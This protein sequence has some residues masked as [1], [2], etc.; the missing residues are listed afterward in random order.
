MLYFRQ[1]QAQ[2][3]VLLVIRGTNTFTQS[4]ATAPDYTWQGNTNTGIFHPATNVIGF[5]NAGAESMRII[6]D[7]AAG[8]PKVIIGTGITLPTSTTYSYSLYVSRGILAERVKVAI[9]TTTDW[10]DKVFTKDHKL[11]SLSELKSFINENGH[12]PN[13]PS[14]EEV[15]KSGID[16]GE[17]DAK[18]L[19]KIE[20]LTLHVIRLEEEINKLKANQNEK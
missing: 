2:L 15:V 9:H 14:A 5:A 1:P 16:L 4:S 19:E 18:L 20:E 11:M 10:S 17:M 6:H 13:I 8:H 7:A 3:P 12:L